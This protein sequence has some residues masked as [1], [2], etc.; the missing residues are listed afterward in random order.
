MRLSLAALALRASRPSFVFPGIR[1]K[2]L[3][4]PT[5]TPGPYTGPQGFIQ[6]LWEEPWLRKTLLREYFMKFTRLA[7][8]VYIYYFWIWKPYKKKKVAEAK[9]KGLPWP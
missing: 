5:P 3:T 8:P 6:M 7:V 9:A 4:R 1:G 2:N